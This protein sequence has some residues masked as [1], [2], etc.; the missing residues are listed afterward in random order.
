VATILETLHT[1]QACEERLASTA[2]DIVY[3]RDNGALYPNDLARY[4]TARVRLYGAQMATYGQIMAILRA[5][6][7]LPGGFLSRIPF[8]ELAP[9]IPPNPGTPVLPP[10]G[11][12]NPIVIAGAGITVSIPVWAAAVLV[13][14]VAVAVV[15]AIVLTVALVAGA[16]IL[17]AKVEE[18]TRKDEVYYH[19]VR[20]LYAQ[21]RAAGNSNAD[22]AALVHGI[23]T[24]SELNPDEGAWMK[25]LAIGGVA[26]VAL[27]GLLTIAPFVLRASG[28]G[29]R[30]PRRYTVGP[31]DED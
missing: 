30:T 24:P 18:D 12:G 22:C 14:I 2:R 20:N 6:T 15:A 25:Y 19:T 10:S 23:R 3:L 28:S 5:T 31:G 4:D 11:T 16:V 13:V 1:L 27:L 9:A 8:P 29:G 26:T 17:V 7:G 21:C